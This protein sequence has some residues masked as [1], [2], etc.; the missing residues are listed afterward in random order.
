MLASRISFSKEDPASASI[1][2]S[3]MVPAESVPRIIETLPNKQ[4]FMVRLFAASTIGAQRARD[5]LQ[6]RR[7]RTQSAIVG[8]W[9]SVGSCSTYRPRFPR[10]GR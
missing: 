6:G 10:R 1:I 9:R 5:E 7:A 4:E 8:H 3:V 2:G